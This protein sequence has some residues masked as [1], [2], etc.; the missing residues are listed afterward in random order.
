MESCKSAAATKVLFNGYFIYSPPVL[1]ITLRN[2]MVR[3]LCAIAAKINITLVYT[4]SD[5]SLLSFHKAY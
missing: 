5:T 4:L 2:L 3:G 1:T